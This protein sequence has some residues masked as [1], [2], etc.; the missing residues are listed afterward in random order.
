MSF[1]LIKRQFR[2]I[3]TFQ[4]TKI[5]IQDYVNSKKIESGLSLPAYINCITILYMKINRR[6][7]ITATGIALISKTIVGQTKKRVI[8]AGAGLSGLSAALELSTKGFEVTVIEGRNRIGG[9]I[10]TMTEPFADN[11]FVEFG[12]ELIGDGY[13]RLLGYAK[14]FNVDFEEVPDEVQTSGSVAALQGGI[15]TTTVMKGKLYPV[16][17]TLNPHPYGLNGEEAGMLPPNLLG[18]YVRQIVKENIGNNKALTEFDKFSLANVLRQRG[19]SETA[20]SLMNISLN[21]NSIETVSAAGILF[22]SNRRIEAGTRAYRVLGGNSQIT[23]ALFDNA[24]KNGVKFIFDAKIKQISQTEN[25]VKVSFRD[26][27]GR[28]QNIRGQK[29]VCTIPFSVLRNVKFSPV[30]PKEKYL[31]IKEL[32]YTQITKVYLQANRFEWDS[33]NYGSSIW[34]DSPCERIFNA[35]GKKGDN[36]GIF[37]MWMDGEGAKKPDKLNDID[38]QIWGKSEF[39]KVLPQMKGSIDR[40]ATKSWGNDEFVRGSY[41]HFTRGQLTTIQPN[42]KTKVGLIHFAGE[43]TAEKAPGMEGALESAERVVAEIMS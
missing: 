24:R 40:T 23:K 3:V 33:K 1:L 27:N 37:T 30:L 8:I 16:G 14:K 41:S 26:K 18:K 15:G 35:A 39:E 36:H 43:H 28:N 38:R 25:S 10:F 4:S 29:L 12:G 32:A 5:L 31:A 13:K 7:F 2:Q 9:R 34:T 17:S 21:Y 42:L 11:Q 22:D 20:I 19:V 6:E